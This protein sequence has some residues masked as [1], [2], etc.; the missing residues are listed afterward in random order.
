MQTTYA[1]ANPYADFDSWDA[2][3]E[4]EEAQLTAEQVALSDA[5]VDAAEWGEDEPLAGGKVFDALYEVTCRKP[6]LIDNFFYY[7]AQTA[8]PTLRAMVREV[9]DAWAVIKSEELQK[10]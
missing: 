2:D 9:A 3:N 5:F 4:Q 10:R 8:N 1:T 6:E 7:A